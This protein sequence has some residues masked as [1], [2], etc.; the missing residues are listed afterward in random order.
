MRISKMQGKNRGTLVLYLVGSI[1]IPVTTPVVSASSFESSLN[2]PQRV[3]NGLEQG[4]G[5]SGYHPGFLEFF[6]PFSLVPYHSTYQKYYLTAPHPTTLWHSPI[7]LSSIIQ[8]HS[9]INLPHY[10]LSYKSIIQA[11]P[12][13]SMASSSVNKILPANQPHTGQLKPGG[14]EDW[15]SKLVENPTP[16]NPKYP[17]LIPKFSGITKG[18]R[19]TSERIEG[20]SDG[21]DVDEL[22]QSMDADFSCVRAGCVRAGYVRAG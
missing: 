7:R 8:P 18:T 21:E 10:P 20:D 5:S 3:S 9:T 19:L 17:W 2:C 13:Q 14:D 6:V 16:M 11:N 15:K 1:L 4:P 22:E 12:T